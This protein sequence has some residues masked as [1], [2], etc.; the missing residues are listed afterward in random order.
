VVA[1]LN[2]NTPLPT[3]GG[4]LTTPPLDPSAQPPPLSIPSIPADA[5]LKDSDY[6]QSCAPVASGILDIEAI[7]IQNLIL[8]GYVK[9]I[10]EWMRTTT[11]DKDKE[12]NTTR[13]ITSKNILGQVGRAT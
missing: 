6:M 10:G 3:P 4:L 8:N 13:R 2:F 9:V 5:V 7:F 12:T 11:R 1:V